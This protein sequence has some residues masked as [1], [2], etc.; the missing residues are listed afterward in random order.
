MPNLH[1]IEKRIKSVSST[2]QITRTMEMVAG[3]KVKHASER[4]ITATP[5][6]ESMTEM[7]QGV[8]ERVQASENPLLEKR[9][10]VKRMLVVAVVSDRGL[11]GGFNS[12]VLRTVEKLIRA[13]KA[14]G[15]SPAAR[16]LLDFSSIARSSRCLISKIFLPTLR[17][18][19]RMP[20]P[21][22]PLRRMKKAVLTRLFWCTTTRRTLLSR[23]C[24]RK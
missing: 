16:R 6:A 24:A 18:K 14:Q 3:A 20:S 17:L 4:I 1:D 12:N 15:V 7:L 11:A 23:F 19:R 10:D 8:A 2:M 22:T 21:I 9:A 13:K 5:Y